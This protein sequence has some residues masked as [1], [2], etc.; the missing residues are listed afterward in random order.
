MQT[1]SPRR[2]TAVLVVTALAI[3]LSFIFVLI[4]ANHAEASKTATHPKVAH[5]NG[6][7]A[8]PAASLKQDWLQA[9]GRL[10]LSFEENHGQVNPA[11]QFFS[12]GDGY[13]L[14]L[15]SQEADFTLRSPRPKQQTRF[16]RSKFLRDRNRAGATEKTSVLRMRLE[17]SNPDAAMTGLDRT[18]TKINYFIGNDPAKW[19]TDVPAYAKVKYAEVYPGVDLIFYGNR[20]QLEYDFV[21]APGADTKAI[22]LNVEG[23]DKMKLDANGNLAMGVVGGIVELRKPNAYQESNG[24]RREV[25]GNYQISKQHEVRF[26]LGDYDKTQPLTIDPVV[27]YSTYVGGSGNA[28]G[29]DIGFGIALD[30][31]GDAYIAGV[32]SS[33][34]LMQVNGINAAAPGSVT[35]STA[36]FVA[37]LNPAGTAA[38]YL[39]YLGGSTSDGAFAI[40]VDGTPN[41]YLTGFT[42]SSDFPLSQTNIPFQNTPPAGVSLGGVAFVTRLDPT[43]TGT[44]QLV[45]SGFVG[46]S[47]SANGG[48][49]GNGIAVDGNGN[50]FLTGLTLSTTTFPTMNATVAPFSS[51]QLSPAGNAFVTEVNTGGSGPT[52]LLF[53]A[54]FGGTGAGNGNFPFGDFGAGIALDSSSKV[55]IVGTTT[56]GAS[57][58]TQGTSVKPCAQNS[59]S[60]AFLSVI[61][62]ST[63]ATPALSYS[64][65]VAGST[66]EIGNGVA[67][68]PS[69]IVYLT[70]ASFSTDFPLVPAGATIPLGFP[71]A[72]PPGFPNSD[73]SVVFVSTL[74]TANGTLGYSTFL[75]GSGGDSGSSIAVDSAGVAYVTGQAGSPDFP[76]TPG[77]AQM[78]RTNGLGNAFVS[79]VNASAGGNGG[80]DLL[81][82]TYFGGTGDGSDPDAGNGI[83]LMGTNAYVTGQATTGALTTAGAYHTATNNAAG[84]NAFVAELPL[85]APLSVSPTSLNFG[86]QLVGAPT[87]A[88]SVTVTNNS[89]ASISIPFVVTGANAA[90]FV[91]QAGATPCGASLAAGAS[92]M[93]AVVFTPS[94]AAAEAA[95][96]Q[97]ATGVNALSVALSGTGSATGAFTVTAPATFDLTSGVAGSV[98]VTVTGS[99]G[100]T[101]AVNL[102]CTGNTPNVT[103]CTMMPTSVTVTSG[104]MSPTAVASVTATVSFVAPPPAA[105]NPPSTSVR[106]VV[107][108]VL[109]ISMLF[110]IPRTQ[111]RR[112]RLG[113]VAAMLV[114]VTVAGCSNNP[115]SHTGT[116]SITITGTAPATPALGPQSATV[117]LTISN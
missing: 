115:K 86:T 74:N 15:M 39:T 52:S 51:V 5:T 45:Y 11:V 13:D 105:N 24:V 71:G 64:T 28:N 87:A 109:G 69:N 63:P 85:L 38:L 111:R 68:G 113:M 54:I 46:G 23:A 94:V 80:K 72:V 93:I 53:S 30:A 62:L 36:A 29:G 6:A 78:T 47:G 90:D 116:G 117:N 70:G 98:P 96:L 81:Y 35:N 41:I 110:M 22:A 104:M 32:T 75:G 3:A 1:P 9:Y 44:A 92:C 73:S 4:R 114:F 40:A 106:Q 26:V 8:A 103:S 55:Y 31:A 20:R 67:L 102:T 107:F 16:N 7:V 88:Q 21:V 97:I 10:P 18:A 50:A 56:S 48:D 100:F 84:L 17:G 76:I 14:S 2:S 59:T 19:H 49:E 34:D 65:C 91:A 27:I 101:G 82:S 83:V 79:K 12:H 108:L 37:E 42:E 33:A 66:A 61:N 25:A 77:A 89:A 95:T 99:Q 60:A 43:K 112:L 58:P 57:F